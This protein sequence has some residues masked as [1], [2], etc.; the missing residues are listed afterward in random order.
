[1]RS[2]AERLEQHVVIEGCE[3]GMVLIELA[4]KG[5]I[6]QRNILIVK[7]LEWRAKRPGRGIGAGLTGADGSSVE[8][9]NG[10][11]AHLNEIS[12]GMFHYASL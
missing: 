12:T 1:M 11:S 4:A 7:L 5:A 3:E 10:R 6:E 8:R 9:S 2:L